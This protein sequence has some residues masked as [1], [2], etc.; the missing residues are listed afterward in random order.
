[1][2][3]DNLNALHVASALMNKVA[4]DPSDVR[5]DELQKALAA[6]ESLI[7]RVEKAQAGFVPGTSQHSLQ[8]NRLSALRVAEAMTMAE[9][10]GC[11][12]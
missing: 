1:M 8:R 9:L 12:A 3:R 7:S 10:H 11:D 5:P 2:L 6:L 4:S